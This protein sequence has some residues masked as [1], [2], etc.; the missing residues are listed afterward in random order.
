LPPEPQAAAPP[1]KTALNNVHRQ[2]GAKMVDFNGWDMPVEYPPVGG[3]MKEHVAVRTGVGVFDVS[4]MGDIRISG[5]QALEAVQHITMNDASKLAIGQ[6]QYSAMLYPEG[7]FVDD[8]I[9]HRLDEKDFLLVIN[10]GTRE[11]DVDWVTQNVR[12]FD[13]KAENLSDDYTQIAIQ[14]PKGVD[15][16]QKLTAEHTDRPHRIYRGRW[17]RNLCADRRSD[18]FTGLERS[19]EG[20]PGVRHRSLRLGRAEHAA[21]R[22][23]AFAVRS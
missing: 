6:A 3:L 14:G 4:H 22:R 7:T 19:A 12:G 1:R 18:Q 13:A 17:I 8:V 2:L 5:S 20:R 21:P 16:L 11:K 23:C 10:A 15:T 9:A